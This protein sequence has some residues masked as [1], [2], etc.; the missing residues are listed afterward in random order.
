MVTLR[1]RVQ[2]LGDVVKASSASP[3]GQSISPMKGDLGT[4]KFSSTPLFSSTSS[5]SLAAAAAAAAVRVSVSP[6]CSSSNQTALQN[7]TQP[8]VQLSASSSASKQL[9]PSVLRSKIESPVTATECDSGRE[10]VAAAGSGRAGAAAALALAQQSKITG[11]AIFLWHAQP[12]LLSK[13]FCS[14]DV[15]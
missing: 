2:A 6:T 11:A 12:T 8:G 7:P 5:S 9:P 13:P 10:N 3:A 4:A 1:A 14:A 15:L